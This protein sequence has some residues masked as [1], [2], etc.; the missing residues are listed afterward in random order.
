MNVSVA[1]Q[2]PRTRI[3]S[4]QGWLWLVAMLLLAAVVIPMLNRFVPSESMFHVPGWVV[5]T[6]GKYMCYAILALAIDLIWGYT[7]ILSLGHAFFFAL[8]AYL[9]GMHLAKYMNDV[10]NTVPDFMAFMPWKE[11]PWFWSGFEHFSYGLLMALLVPAVFAFVLGY[12]AFRS[13]IKGVYFAIITQ[14]LTFAM[15]R[16]FLVNETGFGGNNGFTN[17][18]GIL[19]FSLTNAA[20]TA[21]LGLSGD[22]ATTKLG[23]YIVTAVVLCLC[24]LLCRYL[25]TSKLGRVLRAIR[26]AEPRVAF[27]GYNTA[28]FKMFVWTVSAVLAAIGG[29]LFVPQVGIINPS[30]L[31]PAKSIEAVVWVAVGGRGTLVGAIL[32]TGVVNGTKT[33]FTTGNLADYWLFIL[34]GLAVLVTLVFPGGLI[35]RA[36]HLKAAQSIGRMLGLRS[37][38]DEDR[39]ILSALVPVLVLLFYFGLISL[40]LDLL[41]GDFGWTRFKQVNLLAVLL[42]PVYLLV[43]ALVQS[44]R[45]G[46]SAL[47]DGW[48]ASVRLLTE[49]PASS[50]GVRLLM[51]GTVSILA[52]MIA[53]QADK[54]VG[55][56]VLLGVFILPLWLSSYHDPARCGRRGSLLV[57]CYIALVLSFALFP[58]WFML[59]AVYIGLGVMLAL[60]LLPFMPLLRRA[61]DSPRVS[62]L[63]PVVALV[64]LYP[65]LFFVARQFFPLQQPMS[66]FLKFAEVFFSV[67][68]RIVD[69]AGVSINLFFVFCALIMFYLY[70]R[71][72]QTTGGRTAT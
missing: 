13:R 40:S 41:G 17:F 21:K 45:R 15:W 56:L 8:G 34:G 58:A 7:G 65:F 48:L 18:K 25:V 20:E 38:R 2:P 35:D 22:A 42:L 1:E 24:F 52:A 50:A 14:A 11:F 33:L 71:S 47:A 30:E 60:S 27:S 57:Y 44:Y 31:H 37:T 19:G 9:M 64:L 39:Y 46:R 49:I 66:F 43:N 61:L 55:M 6:L 53:W 32:G 28:R 72:G 62:T 70:R 10:L 59:A 54:P 5:E 69:E 26:D 3:L 51:L 67:S 68:T 63:L 36:S 29:I 4:P 23:L 12:F 16:L